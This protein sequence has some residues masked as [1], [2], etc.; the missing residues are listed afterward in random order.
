MNTNIRSCI[1]VLE[2]LSLVTCSNDVLPM[3]ERTLKNIQ[4]IL[5]VDTRGVEPLIWQNELSFDRLHKDEVK[6][7]L[8]S[9]DLK[10]NASGFFEDYIT[11]GIPPKG[12]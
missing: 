11:V 10:K 12:R 5:E 3:L 4:P 7:R 1:K 8:R 9:S 6:N 2:K